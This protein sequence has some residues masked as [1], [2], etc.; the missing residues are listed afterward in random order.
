MEFKS[1]RYKNSLYL[2]LLRRKLELSVKLLR[3]AEVL[4]DRL[5]YLQDR[6]HDP[7]VFKGL[8]GCGL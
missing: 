3:E 5:Y 4:F 8:V 6:G 1:N 7:V 2:I